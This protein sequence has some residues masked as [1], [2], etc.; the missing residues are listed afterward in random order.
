M[1]EE[2]MPHRIWA[3]PDRWHPGQWIGRFSTCRGVRTVDEPQPSME[4]A[5]FAAGEAMCAYLD[6]LAEKSISLPISPTRGAQKF[7]VSRNG[8]KSRPTLMRR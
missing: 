2:R 1:A 3:D 5:K 7:T 4:A 8:R 6:E